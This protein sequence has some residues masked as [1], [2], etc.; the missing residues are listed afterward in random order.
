MEK[1]DLNWGGFILLLLFLVCVGFCGCEVKAESALAQHRRHNPQCG[2]AYFAQFPTDDQKMLFWLLIPD[3]RF[4]EIWE[5][6]VFVVTSTSIYPPCDVLTEFAP[7]VF[8]RNYAGVTYHGDILLDKKW[9]GGFIAAIHYGKLE[10]GERFLE[11]GELP[12]EVWLRTSPKSQAE[13]M[14]LLIWKRV[15]LGEPRNK[16]PPL[17]ATN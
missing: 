10:S 1:K 15:W 8:K 6:H 12:Y 2:E 16:P 5:N 7:R 11:V 4:L 17:T 3:N 13:V 14:K 9:M